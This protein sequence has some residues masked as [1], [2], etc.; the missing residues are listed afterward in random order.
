MSELKHY[1][2]NIGGW[3]NFHELYLEMIKQANKDSYFVEVGSFLGKSA[4]YMAVEIAN[5]NKKIKFDCVDPWNGLYLYDETIACDKIGDDFFYTGQ[6]DKLYDRYYNIFVENMKPVEN[7]YSAVRKPSLEASQLYEDGQ[8]DFVFL[9][10][11]HDYESVKKDIT[12]WWPK[13]KEGGVLAGHDYELDS[14]N[15]AVNE[16][17]I[18]PP[19]SF[20]GAETDKSE[21]RFMWETWYVIKGKTNDCNNSA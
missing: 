7:Y 13:I 2:T 19:Q 12:H 8:L 15:F 1:Y 14:V 5:S 17:F 16:C 10:G 20:L 21:Q 18:P 4:A 9:D 11:L 3:F 6:F